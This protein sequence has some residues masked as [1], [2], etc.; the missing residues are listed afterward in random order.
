MRKNFRDANY[1]KQLNVEDALTATV[2]PASGSFIDMTNHRHIVFLVTVGALDSEL[3]LQVG[4]DTSATQT[5]SI[6]DVS[7]ATVTIEATDDDQTFAIEV[8]DAKLDLAN[9]FRY[10]TLSVAG[11]AGANDYAAITAIGWNE[12]HEPVTQPSDFPAANSVRVV[13]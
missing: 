1:V 3:T 13:G 6:K 12:R 5:A 11:A 7:G 10:V 4:Q 8:E 2:Y 9:G